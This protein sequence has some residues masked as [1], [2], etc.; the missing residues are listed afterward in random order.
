MRLLDKLERK[1]GKFYIPNLILY[2]L[3]ITGVVYLIEFMSA[4]KIDLWGLMMLYPRSVLNGQIWRIFTFV[5]V[6]QLGSPIFFIFALY[7]Y[8]MAGKGLE[9]EWGEFKFNVYY[10]TGALAT[11]ILSFLTGVPATAAS[12]NLSLFLAFAR[13]Y[14]D[15]EI[16]L[17]FAI[18]IKVRYL[19]WFNWALILYG[20]ITAPNMMSRLLTLAPAINFLIFFGRDLVGGTKS[21]TKNYKR[22]RE[23]DSKVI[24]FKDIPRHKCVVCGITEKDDPDMQFRYC[25]KCS[26]NKCYCIDHIGNHEHK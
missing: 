7:F 1:M 9:D 11:I 10:F 3:G 6:E 15:Y 21:Y 13:I 19:G 18:P 20:F 2:V 4:G 24:Q 8:Y 17:F 16:L 25:S 12:I 23:F 14:P 5:F 22:K 26:G